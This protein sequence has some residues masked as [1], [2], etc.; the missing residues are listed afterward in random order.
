MGVRYLLDTHVLIWMAGR[1]RPTSEVA[2]LLADETAMLIVS[3]VTAFE[4]ATKV[5]LGKLE[6][7]RQLVPDWTRA[8]GRIGATELAMTRHHALAAG[9]LDWEHRDPF[10]RLLVAQALVEDLTLVT[11]DRAM[12]GAPDVQLL[13]W[14]TR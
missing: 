14:Q 3:S 10:D 13:R 6:S 5:R 12:T 4:I 9:S 1:G 7:A 11:A 2:A 8:L